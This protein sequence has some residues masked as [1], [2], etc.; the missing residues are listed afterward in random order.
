LPEPQVACHLEELLP[1]EPT[2][3]TLKGREYVLARVGDEVF[4]LRNLCP[5]QSVSFSAG[6][7]RPRLS[8]AG[9]ESAVEVDDSEPLLLCPW[10]SWAFS[11]RDGSCPTDPSMR[12][13][14]YAVT[15]EDGQ[16]LI[17]DKLRSTVAV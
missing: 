3:I 4:A 14:R 8:C 10:H 15:V 7:V 12:V 5:H 11:L 1:N 13:A 17:G 2:I 9:P 16:V 6:R